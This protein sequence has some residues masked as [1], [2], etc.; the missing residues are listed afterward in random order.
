MVSLSDAF[1]NDAMV[2]MTSSLSEG[3]C[4]CGC[5]LFYMPPLAMR[6]RKK[7]GRD[8]V[9]F[10]FF[11]DTYLGSFGLVCFGLEWV[12]LCC[13]VFGLLLV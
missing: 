6:A 9:F 12:E 3:G 2:D 11:L 7:Q 13:C 8:A 10:F 4:V 1:F 5:W